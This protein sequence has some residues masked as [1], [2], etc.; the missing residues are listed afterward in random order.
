MRGSAWRPLILP[1]AAALFACS[2][3]DTSVWASTGA[4]GLVVGD[5]GG[6]TVELAKASYDD[7]EA[8][9]QEVLE[10]SVK[11][12]GSGAITLGGCGLGSLELLNG[13]QA[14]CPVYGTVA[15]KEVVVPDD[16][17]VLICAQAS[18]LNAE[19]SCDVTSDASGR[20]LANGWLQN[21]PRDG[22]RFR[23]ADGEV[24]AELFYEEGNPACSSAAGREAFLTGEGAYP[25]GTAQDDFNLFCRGEFVKE[26]ADTSI[27]RQDN[28]CPEREAGADAGDSGATGGSA[29]AADSGSAGHDGGFGGGSGGSGGTGNRG[30]TSG[31]GT[32][33]QSRPDAGGGAGGSGGSRP[34]PSSGGAAQTGAGGEQ[35]GAPARSAPP[36]EAGGCTCTLA[37]AVRPRGTLLGALA[38][39][40]L[41]RRR[42]R[43]KIG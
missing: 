8:D 34:S 19:H 3:S 1:S 33:G 22:F 27:L 14:S 36:P 10:L 2:A 35:P 9:D 28:V 26:F 7:P 32:G 16:G 13:G 42:R 30:G 43:L 25:S 40:A 31:G 11:R 18:L 24:T 15:L 20:A 41:I 37:S 6:C 23:A 12:R 17:F 5:T 29:G 4:S 39:L 21:G 38:L